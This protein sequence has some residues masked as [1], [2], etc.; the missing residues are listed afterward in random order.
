[1]RILT[2]AAAGFDEWLR[3]RRC[4]F[5]CLSFGFVSGFVFFC[6][7]FLYFYGGEVPQADDEA[8]S[9][10]RRITGP[11]NKRHRFN[12]NPTHFPFGLSRCYRILFPLVPALFLL[13]CL[14][15]FDGSQIM[16]HQHQVNRNKK[17]SSIDYFVFNTYS[18]PT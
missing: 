10:R 18:N 13:F 3:L 16:K 1:M 4:P 8:D 5:F 11:I 14:V 9:L 6:F 12:N 17:V 15:F 7:F 2:R